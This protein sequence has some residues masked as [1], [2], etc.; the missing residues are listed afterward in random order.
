[1]VGT[2]TGAA[3]N[4]TA[5]VSATGDV[6]AANEGSA[7]VYG[8]G[9]I[10]AVGAVGTSSGTALSGSA[11][12][13]AAGSVGTLSGAAV[14]GTGTVTAAGTHG[15]TGSA[16]IGATVTITAEGLV[17]ETG[18]TSAFIVGT[19]TITAAGVVISHDTDTSNADDGI[20]LDGTADVVWEPAV[21]PV[22]TLIGPR[23]ERD[24]RV[25]AQVI[26]TA[27]TL[28]PNFAKAAGR[29]E[30]AVSLRERVLIGNR[31]VTFLRGVPVT[32]DNIRL[33]DPLLYGSAS[34]TLPQVDLAYDTIG[35][36]DL[37]F[38]YDFAPVR[39]QL[40]D[41]D[42][43]VVVPDYYKGFVLRINT[44]GPSV[45][46]DVAGQAAGSLSLLW[47]PQPTYR[48]KQDVEHI[49]VDLLR[50]AHV[51]AH[52]HTG[53]SGVGI[54]RRGAS[55]G[56]T[57]FNETLSVWAG[58]TASPIT[59]TPR[60]SDGAYRKTVKD[61]ATIHGTIYVDHSLISPSIARDLA[62]ENRRVYASGFTAAGELVTNTKTP[63]LTQGEV[64]AFPLS[65][66]SLVLDM[67]DADTLTGAGVTALQEQLALHDFLDVE[68]ADAGVF[69]SATAAAVV[70]FKT[71]AGL[72]SLTPAVSES[73][74]NVLW[75]L[76]ATNYS[77]DDAR[78]YPMAEDPAVRK[79]NR[80]SNGSKIE[81]NPLYDPHVKPVGEF[82]EVGGPWKHREIRDFAHSRLRSEDVWVGTLTLRSGLVRGEHNPG[83]PFTTADVMDRRELVPNMRL[84]LPYFQGGKV[85]YVTGV[86]HGL[87]ETQ[88]S[89]ST[90]PETTY[91]TWAAISR[92]REAKS[93]VARMAQGHVRASQVRRDTGPSWDTSSGWIANK[94][95]VA[96]GWNEIEVPAG[97]AGIVQ[98]VKVELETPDEFALLLTKKRV[99]LSA[100]N[101][102]DAISTPLTDPRPASRP[103]FERDAIVDWLETRGYLDAWGTEDQPCGYDPQPKTDERGATAAAITGKFVEACGL[104]YETGAEPVLYLYVWV[105]TDNHLLPGR[106]LRNQRTADF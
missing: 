20:G 48:R 33:I 88:V 100:L 1:V 83:D 25:A 79:W 80:T 99:S 44:D 97:Q 98:R 81:A 94:V 4:G 93:N 15:L 42:D 78:E 37:A 6:L 71:D 47:V 50:D 31:D 74:W 45:S 68:D 101:S 84:W 91:E 63:G 9:T 85:F 12:L 13:S 26:D 16:T 96:A 61:T 102:R 76:A 35:A 53:S 105:G 60:A 86:E 54:I 69:D 18:T 62:T 104:N 49:C 34:V 32:V 59:F 3:V 82:I 72:S 28:V 39:V 106:I 29:R 70:A 23:V 55:D 40:V 65:S 87:E 73:T 5:T 19:A 8:T 89:V 103:W 30:Y 43:E 58:S 90:K 11:S 95:A 57:I 75:N 17:E 27:P 38:L 10:T 7:S 51:R 64:P 56:L 22:P 92:V 21:V 52:E 77:L 36:G 46:L 41:A 67:T 66:G 2:S 24:V 14:A